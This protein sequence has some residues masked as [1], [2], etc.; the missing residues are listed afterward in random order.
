MSRRPVA[1]SNVTSV[2]DE[3]GDATLPLRPV[4]RR[5]IARSVWRLWTRPELCETLVVMGCE[6]V[7]RYDW[8]LTARIFRAHYRRLTGFP[9]GEDDVRLLALPP[10]Y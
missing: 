5:D 3:V 10:L 8:L 7:A 9:R 1:C 6:K 4:F 2:P